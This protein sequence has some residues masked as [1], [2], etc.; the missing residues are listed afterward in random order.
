MLLKTLQLCWEPF[1]IKAGD[2]SYIDQAYNLIENV[3]P[4]QGSPVNFTK[5]LKTSVLYNTLGQMILKI[6]TS[7][8]EI[9]A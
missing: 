4:V 3:I 2:Q 6:Y 1:C 7:F 5:S 8:V 9:K